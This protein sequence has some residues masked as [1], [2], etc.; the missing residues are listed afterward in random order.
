MN[1]VCV[2]VLIAV[3]MHHNTMLK[4]HV[5]VFGSEEHCQIERR[6]VEGLLLHEGVYFCQKELLK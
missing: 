1:T 4:E 5:A 6:A 3:T 2:W